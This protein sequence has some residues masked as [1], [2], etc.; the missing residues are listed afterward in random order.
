VWGESTWGS[1][2]EKRTF[3]HWQSISGEGYALSVAAQVT[4]GSLS[5]PDI[6]YVQTDMTFDVADIVT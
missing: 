3:R 2:V 4:S 6:E 5:P 1:E